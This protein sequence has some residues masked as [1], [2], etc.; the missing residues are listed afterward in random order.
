MNYLCRSATLKIPTTFSKYKLPMI[1][2]NLRPDVKK[3]LEGD[4]P[5]CEMA[6]FTDGR[7]ARND[8]PFV[9]LRLHYLTKEFEL[10]KLSL[11]CQSFIGRQ[12]GFAC[13]CCE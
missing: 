13:S 3:Q 8:D 11:D 7:T 10:K 1:Y 4:I 12:W 6:D 2:R 9:S 5:Y